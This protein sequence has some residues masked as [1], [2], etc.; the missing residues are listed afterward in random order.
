MGGPAAIMAEADLVRARRAE[1]LALLAMGPAFQMRLAG[2][3]TAA[4]ADRPAAGSHPALAAA[5]AG[6]VAPA[7]RGW[8]GST[9]TSSGTGQVTV[10]PHDGP[11]WGGLELTGSG[12]GRL[13]RVSLSVGWLARVWACGLAVVE[14]NLV[15]AVHEARWPHARVLALPEPGAAPVT[16]AVRAVAGGGPGTGTGGSGP[17]GSGDDAHWVVTDTGEEAAQT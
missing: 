17:A 9:S 14:G 12:A 2:T 5:L 1:L 6:R 15:V 8:L 16:L 7:V 11:G 13:L 3:V 4:W 10:V